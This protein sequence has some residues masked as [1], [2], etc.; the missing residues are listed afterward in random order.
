MTSTH[1]YGQNGR[2]SE[3]EELD[4]RKQ[5]NIEHANVWTED[6]VPYTSA[7]HAQPER[8]SSAHNNLHQQVHRYYNHR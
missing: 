3:E 6:G 8:H 4:V 5:A 1:E 7:V 2:A